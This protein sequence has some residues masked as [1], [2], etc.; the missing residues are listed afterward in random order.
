MLLRGGLQWHNLLRRL[1]VKPIEKGG[2]ASDN[3]DI[4]FWRGWHA[5]GNCGWRLSLAGGT[6]CRCSVKWALHDQTSRD[7][8][9]LIEKRRIGPEPGQPD[10]PLSARYRCR[11]SAPEPDSVTVR[12]NQPLSLAPRSRADFGPKRVVRIKIKIIPLFLFFPSAHTF[13]PSIL[14]GSRG[15]V[16]LWTILHVDVFS[17]L[18]CTTAVDFSRGIVFVHWGPQPGLQCTYTWFPGVD[19]CRGQ[20]RVRCYEKWGEIGTIWVKWEQFNVW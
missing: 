2:H 8:I 20:L 1:K 17:Y 4:Y 9:Q 3:D 15:W 11:N 12:T 7:R 13:P 6:F 16:L 19:F 10:G 18:F 5:Q 14:T